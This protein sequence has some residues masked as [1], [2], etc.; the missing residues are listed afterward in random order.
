MEI[1]YNKEDFFNLIESRNIPPTALLTLEKDGLIP[2]YGKCINNKLHLVFKEGPNRNK[3]A[4]ELISL[5][6]SSYGYTYDFQAIRMSYAS[7]PEHI[8]FKLITPRI[9]K[10][11]PL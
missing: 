11:K 9:S 5:I 6:G 3:S 10:T 2:W 4:A 7:S 8:V 1:T